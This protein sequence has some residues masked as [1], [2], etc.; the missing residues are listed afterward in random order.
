MA[1]N[2][3]IEELPSWGLPSIRIY[4]HLKMS[5]NFGKQLLRNDIVIPRSFEIFCHAAN[6]TRE[7]NSFSPLLP[8]F[9]FAGDASHLRH[10]ERDES[11]VHDIGLFG[12][13]RRRS[14]SRY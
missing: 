2:D 14:L 6:K 4:L 12:F 5:I 13:V 8:L 7:C 9:F 1:G 11:S 10:S 3:L